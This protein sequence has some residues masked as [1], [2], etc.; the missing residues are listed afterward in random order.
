MRL[1]KESA[2][3]REA[4]AQAQREAQAAFGDGALYLEKFLTRVRHVEVQVLGDASTVLHF[5]E[6]DCSTQ[7]RNQKLVEETPAAGLSA[8]FRG[9]MHQ[10]AVRLSQSVGYTSAGTIEFIVDEAAQEFYFMEMNTRI[11]VEHP[12]TEMVTGADLVKCQIRIAAGEGSGYDQ[13]DITSTG[14][15]IECRINAE[16]PDQGF[17][18]SPGRVTGFHCPGGPGI[19]V[20]SQLYQ[21]YVIP[22]YYDSL[23]AKL[24]AWGRDREE[25]ISRM[26]RALAE[27]RVEG[28]KTTIPFHQK[29]LDDAQFRAGKVYTRYIE[30]EFLK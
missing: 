17:A 28:V 11:Q 30:Q 3:M 27:M 21:D 5:G 29:L 6:R 12:V 15:S 1:V 10:A 7:R 24:I 8:K 18:P 19:R 2:E 16:D 25:A 22:P 9:D 20:D 23:I 4:F 14:H 13:R 26:Q